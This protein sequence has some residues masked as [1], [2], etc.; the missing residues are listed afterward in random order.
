[1]TDANLT[2][3]DLSPHIGTE[4]RGLDLNKPLD[5]A[6]IKALRKVWID[7]ALLVF[8]GQELTQEALVRF[9]G[10]FGVAGERVASANTRYAKAN[11]LPQIMLISNVRENGETIGA[12]PD[13]ELH[14]HHD[15]I[16]TELPHMASMLYA[17]EV[18]SHGGETCFAAGYAAYDTLDPNIK[19]RLEGKRV[20]HTYRYGTTKRGDLTGATDFTDHSLHPAFRAHDETKRKAIYVNRLMSMRVEGLER[21]G[22]RRASQ[23]NI[24]PCREARIRLLP[25]SGRSVTS[26]CGT[27]AIQCMPA[28]ISRPISGG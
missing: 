12:L 13:G 16:Q 5:E 23:R 28:R 10:Y 21:E 20:Y 3:V 25:S 15:M 1:M 11:I 27:T 14:F 8:R 26:C 19:A 17:R 9:T 6:T 24:R 7:R 4:V 2:F 18:P 22:K